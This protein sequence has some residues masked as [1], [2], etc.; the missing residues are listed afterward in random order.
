M[1]GTINS[2]I[3]ISTSSKEKIKNAG[4]FLLSALAI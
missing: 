3:T 2:P 4:P 1:T